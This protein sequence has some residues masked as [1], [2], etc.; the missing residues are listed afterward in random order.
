MDEDLTSRFNTVL[1]RL[2]SLTEILHK[3]GGKIVEHQKVIN[4]LSEDNSAL[5]IRQR[6]VDDKVDD[7][8]QYTRR[9]TLEIFGIPESKD[10]DTLVTVMTVGRA[11]KRIA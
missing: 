4:S 5:R 3:Q 9:N 11:L 10:E 7:R 8:E 6:T 1:S 2:D